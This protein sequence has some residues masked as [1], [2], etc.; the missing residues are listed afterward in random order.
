[1]PAIKAEAGNDGECCRESGLVFE[2]Q[3]LPISGT[4]IAGGE[5]TLDHQQG[6]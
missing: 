5:S 6:E 3:S 4:S 2:G 1:M